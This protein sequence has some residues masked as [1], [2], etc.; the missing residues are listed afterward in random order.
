MS[1]LSS[2]T[3]NGQERDRLARTRLLGVASIV[4]PL[5]LFGSSVAFVSGG[6]MNQ[7]ELGGALLVYAMTALILVIG[8]LARAIQET[9]P[10]T[11]V[12]LLVL[13]VIGCAG[14]IGFGI[15]SIHAALPG[16]AGLEDANS[17]AGAIA[18]FLPG[19]L[20]PFSFAWLGVALARAD[21]RPR[22][23]GPLLVVA[24][25]LFPIANVPDIEI[26][27]V[28]ADAMFVVALAPLGLLLLRG[29]HEGSP[30]PGTS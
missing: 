6:G 27:A 1:A 9:S 20:F 11:S 15:D 25:V 8:G 21:V 3:L 16:G 29:Q 13:G 17:S 10:R 26:L 30:S 7:D 28:I 22:S 4:G 23:T 14:G 19:M 24:A 2:R 12:A 5:L 18:L